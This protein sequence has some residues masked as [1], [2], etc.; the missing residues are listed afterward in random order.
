MIKGQFQPSINCLNRAFNVILQRMRYYFHILLPILA[1]LKTLRVYEIIVLIYIHHNYFMPV[2]QTQ[3]HKA[4][5][6]DN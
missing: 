6:V 2:L 4:F 3:N 5:E 1:A